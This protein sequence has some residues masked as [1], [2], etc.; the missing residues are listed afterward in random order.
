MLVFDCVNAT[1]LDDSA[2]MARRGAH[3]S[4]EQVWGQLKDWFLDDG[5]SVC[6]EDEDITR[7]VVVMNEVVGKGW[8]DLL[9][10]E[11]DNLGLEIE[12]KLLEEALDDLVGKV[13]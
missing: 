8:V 2:D 1:I 9:R 7:L 3:I 5:S 6:R 10:L 13:L 12:R 11:I 4:S